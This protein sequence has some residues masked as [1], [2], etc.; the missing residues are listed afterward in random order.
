M[1]LLS[2]TL[3]TADVHLS[4]LGDDP[5]STDT[6]AQVEFRV[7]GRSEQPRDLVAFLPMAMV[8]TLRVAGALQ[9]M[10]VRF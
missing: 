7:H 2:K 10:S 3:I 4:G 8:G 1:N 9:H 5:F 6:V